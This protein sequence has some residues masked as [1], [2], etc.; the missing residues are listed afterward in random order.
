MDV[1]IIAE[2]GFEV[3]KKVVTIENAQKLAKGF[4]KV[5]KGGVAI[6]AAIHTLEKL[7]D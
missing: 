2:K 4:E 3:A 1:K 6:F 5:C 7:K